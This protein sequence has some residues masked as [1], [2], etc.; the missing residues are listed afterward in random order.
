MHCNDFA[1]LLEREPDGPLPGPAAAHLGSCSN[2]RLLLEDLERIRAAGLEWGAGEPAPPERLWLALRGQL[3]AEGLIRPPAPARPITGWLGQRFAW[4]MRPALVGVSFSLL[5]MATALLNLQV[6][7]TA[8]VAG[9]GVT[10]L[11]S[12]SAAATPGE[13]IDRALDGDMRRVMASLPRHRSS[14]ETAFQQNLN[15]VDN[16][17]A[18]CEKSVRE[19]PN[20]PVAREYLYGAYQQKAVLLSAAM[21]RTTTL[22]GR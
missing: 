2:C 1:D 6:A 14:L 4:A 15:I 7:P 10:E 16:L 5:L 19:Q 13:E 3:E 17:I 9:R 12:L 18:V 22:E 21:D 11:S 20:N 8:G